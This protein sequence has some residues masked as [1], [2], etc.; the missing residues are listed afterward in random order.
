YDRSIQ[1]FEQAI[2][3]DSNF[4]LAYAGLA[5]TYSLQGV[6]MAAELPPKEV[7]EKA[8]GA[9]LKALELDDTLAEAHAALGR[10]KIVYD[11]DS[12]GAEKE[13]QLAIQ[14]NPSYA[15]G[16]HWYAIM[17]Q[18]MGRTD[19]SWTK[20]QRAQALDPMSPNINRVVGD[21]L[22]Q[23]KQYEEARAYL[24]LAIDLG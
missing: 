18:A 7:M 17:L 22:C 23:K 6:S 13:F 19:E 15:T 5:D 11:M 20:I 8:R 4:A 24:Q 2:A 1:Y 10:V 14:Y 9:A 3:K 16:Y 21:Q 12:V